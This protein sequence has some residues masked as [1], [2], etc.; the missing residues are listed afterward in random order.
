MVGVD[1]CL[2]AL[3]GDGPST[4]EARACSSAGG[5]LRIAV[6]G[7]EQ[8][9]TAE[10]G[11]S[12]ALSSG[13]HVVAVL[14][15]EPRRPGTARAGGGR[16]RRGPAGRRHR[17]RQPDAVAARCA[18]LARLGGGRPVVVAGNADATPDAVAA[19]SSAGRGGTRRRQ[20]PA[21]GGRARPR[22]RPR[23]AAAGLP[24]PRH[25][26]QAPLRRPPVHPARAGGDAG[27]RAGRQWSCSPRAPAR[28][29]GWATWC[30]W[31]SG[32]PPPTSTPW[33]TRPTPRRPSRPAPSRAT[34]GCAGAHRARWRRPSRPGGWRTRARLSPLRSGCVTTRAGFPRPRGG[35]RLR[36]AA[37]PLGDRGGAA[38]AR[39]PC[40]PPLRR[41]RPQHRALGRAR[42]H[43][44]ARGRPGGGLRRACS[45]T[46]CAAE[47]TPPSW[48]GGLDPARGLA[49]APGAR[50]SGSTPTTWWPP[51]GCSPRTTPPP[52]GSSWRPCACLGLGGRGNQ[53]IPL[54][55]AE[56]VDESGE[57]P[58]EG[59][60]QRS[61]R[62]APEPP[63]GSDDPRP[64][65]PAWL[66]RRLRSSWGPAA[67]GGR[68]SRGGTRHPAEA[69][70]HHE[71]SSVP[72]ASTTMSGTSN[73]AR[74]E[75][76]YGIDLAAAWSWRCLVIVGCGLGGPPGRRAAGGR[77]PARRRRALRRSPDRPGRRPADPRDATGR[78]LAA[79]RARGARHS[80]W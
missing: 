2:R 60:P 75:V 41:H 29:K 76:P 62:G 59:D 64:E 65:A 49:A 12:V 26:R 70:A 73:F 25:R 4:V 69:R 1:A 74:A 80:S 71:M 32:A 57:G 35:A 61:H 52:P 7:N 40:P 44:P 6:V 39:G 48:F 27:C 51:P 79:G 21:A 68:W 31:T 38:P 56:A 46:R 30:S 63:G 10:A 66:P 5:G 28:A 37:G 53:G 11:R 24:D 45:G 55:Y 42:R 34:W 19:L 13:G 22:A 9:I 58:A 3:A 15:G 16:A 36:P 33:C 8:L 47:R 18:G 78:R 72:R 20:R 23:G 54:I 50:G 77:A 67:A 17:R 43:R 14:A